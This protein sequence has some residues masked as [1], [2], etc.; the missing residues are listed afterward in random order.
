MFACFQKFWLID[1]AGIRRRAA[2]AS[3]GG[4]TETLS[5]NRAFRAIRH[6]DVA[7]VIE[8]VVCITEQVSSYEVIFRKKRSEVLKYARDH[9]QSSFLVGP[10]LLSF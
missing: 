3:L 10:L 1:T 5:M 7:L 9:G 4:M 2:V 6:S 8:A